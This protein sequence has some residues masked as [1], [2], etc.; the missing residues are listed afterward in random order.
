MSDAEARELARMGM[1]SEQIETIRAQQAEALGLDEYDDEDDDEATGFP[2]FAENWDAAQIFLRLEF[3]QQVDQGLTV[4]TGVDP[5]QIEHWARLL[6]LPA[7]RHLAISDSVLVMVRTA[8]RELNRRGVAAMR[9]Q[10]DNERARARSG[11]KR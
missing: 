3:Q 4:Y 6:G 9:R 1:S 8:C 7:D 10:V 11:G 5:G 2:V